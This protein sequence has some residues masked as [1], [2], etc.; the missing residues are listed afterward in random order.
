MNVCAHLCTHMWRPE[1]NTG[2]EVNIFIFSTVFFEME[3]L[4]EPRVHE[5]GE[6]LGV[7]IITMAK[8]DARAKNQNSA[9]MPSS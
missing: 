9:Y 4:T 1:V 2:P 3:F 5:F 6:A 7:G 8:H